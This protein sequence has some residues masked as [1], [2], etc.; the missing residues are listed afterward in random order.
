MGLLTQPGVTGPDKYSYEDIAGALKC[1][2]STHDSKA[3]ASERQEMGGKKT[4]ELH[5]IYLSA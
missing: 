5:A 4:L 3:N 1:V 2:V